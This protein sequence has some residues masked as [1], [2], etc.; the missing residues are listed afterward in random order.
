MLNFSDIISSLS[1]TRPGLIKKKI[2]QAVVNSRLAEPG[3]LFVAIKGEHA[4]GHDFVIDAF[5]QGASAALVEKPL[6]LSPDICVTLD[7][8][9]EVPAATLQKLVETDLPAC[10]VVSDNLLALQKLAALIRQRSTATFIGVTGTF[11]K[12]TTKETIARVLA[13]QYRTQKS[14]G[15]YNNEIG[16]PLSLFS[17]KP[18]TEYMV[19]EMGFYVPGEIKL[20]CDIAQPSIGVLTNIGA[21]HAERAGSLETIA[22]GKGELVE[23]LPAAPRGI[24]ILNDDDPYVREF[25]TR[26]SARVF[27][28]STISACDL[29][30]ENIQTHGLNGIELD[31]HFGTQLVHIKSPLMGAHSAYTILRAASV[32][33][34]CGISLNAI[35]E[36]LA[37][38][39]D[40]LRLQ[41]KKLAN[42]TLIIDD[43]YNA[44]PDS[45]LAAL[46]LLSEIPGKR[47]AILGDMLELGIYEEE[48]H[49]R[50]GKTAAACVDE[51]ITFGNRSLITAQ[52]ARQAGL[53]EVFSFAPHQ[54][55][56]LVA[57]LLPRLDGNEV[58]L[59]KG[60]FSMGMKRIVSALEAAA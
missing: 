43:S 56:E 47:L 57:N 9:T 28:Y 31:L 26:T 3:S 8:R 7:L 38:K 19:L 6:N 48:S 2:T 20:L 54:L 4:D 60:S 1:P 51:L 15:N 40:Q 53:A 41:P 23:S 55:D 32:G 44:G 58:I 25:H 36:T 13:S 5:N 27:R 18:D 46:Q 45:T 34:V 37:Q 16:L 29:W 49:Q 59:I 39:S 30:A 50:V 17:L 10:F 24:A 52:A 35:A 12:T 42:G 21:V 33:L 22:L 11:G 14:E